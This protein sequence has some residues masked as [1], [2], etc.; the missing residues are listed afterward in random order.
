MSTSVLKTIDPDA[1][2]L[3]AALVTIDLAHGLD[4]AEQ[5][6][7]GN[8][9][10]AVGSLLL[11]NAAVV[12]TQKEAKKET[13][14]PKKET[15]TAKQEEKKKPESAKDEGEQQDKIIREYRELKKQVDDLR[16]LVEG[17]T[18]L[19]ASDNKERK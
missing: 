2:T 5:N 16:I 13:E 6:I 3:I 18:R 15:E 19:L 12:Q 4:V 9:I 17:Y 10:V 11:T 14:E 7:L 8:F 1:L